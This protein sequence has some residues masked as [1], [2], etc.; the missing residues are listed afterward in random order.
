MS[1]IKKH[2]EEL[3]ELFVEF[4]RVTSVIQL[5]I[6]A[7]LLK[8]E[9]SRKE[10]DEISKK[11]EEV[12]QEKMNK[13]V[14]AFIAAMPLATHNGINLVMEALS[15]HANITKNPMMHQIIEKLNQKTNEETE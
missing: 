3:T 5:Q 10:F 14:F 1:D 8:H 4:N 6:S 12:M 2:I 7:E 11:S 9:I 15:L 13:A